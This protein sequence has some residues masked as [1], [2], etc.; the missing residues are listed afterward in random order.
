MLT[1]VQEIEVPPA[2]AFWTEATVVNLEASAAVATDV[3]VMVI[4][5]ASSI[6]PGI[7]ETCPPRCIWHH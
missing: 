1:E 3:R 5:P 2:G 6:L 7:D 4:G